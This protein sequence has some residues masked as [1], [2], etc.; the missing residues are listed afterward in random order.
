MHSK[1]NKGTKVF[2][3]TAPVITFFNFVLTNAEPFP[4]FT[5]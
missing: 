3:K 4:G 5:C 2:S 1:G